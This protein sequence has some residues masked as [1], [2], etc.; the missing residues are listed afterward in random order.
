MTLEST[1]E[2]GEALE[3]RLL[4]ALDEFMDGKL[5]PKYQ[6]LYRAVDEVLHDV[7]DP[8]GVSGVP[9]AR[10]EY[11]GYLPD[12]LGL[13]LNGATEKSIATYLG[14]VVTNRMGL[15]ANPSHDREVAS[16]LIDWKDALLISQ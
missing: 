13:L 2:W 16:A 12:V 15:S 5:Y 4:L 11:L 6:A 3:H 14:E 9:H 8:I 1:V 10:E 7:W